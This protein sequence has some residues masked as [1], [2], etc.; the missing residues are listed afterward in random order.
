MVF[1]GE[2]L[3]G[4]VRSTGAISDWHTHCI[5]YQGLMLILFPSV[6]GKCKIT[7]QPELVVDAVQIILFNSQC[8]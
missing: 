1:C 5:P 2:I 6:A 8:S 7:H 4:D 3:P